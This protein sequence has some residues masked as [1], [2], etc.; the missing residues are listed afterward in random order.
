[1]KP[2]QRETAQ[3]RQVQGEQRE[4]NRHHTWPLEVM[5]RQRRLAQRLV[6][7]GEHKH[8]RR[9]HQQVEHRQTANKEEGQPPESGE[10]GGTESAS[11]QSA[12][13]TSGDEEETSCQRRCQ[14]R[15]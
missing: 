7:E 4:V 8:H 10:L 2:Q 3:G 5:V 1:M 11:R 12:D 9:R 15:E 14:A 13:T 6:T